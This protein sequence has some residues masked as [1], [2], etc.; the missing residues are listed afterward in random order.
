MDDLDGE[1]FTLCGCAANPGVNELRS[2]EYGDNW[3]SLLRV[4]SDFCAL[5][6]RSL[7]FPDFGYVRLGPEV[8]MFLLTGIM[9]FLLIIRTVLV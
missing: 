1:L 5:T 3:S 4:G 7:S 6:C 9:C 8:H 2:A